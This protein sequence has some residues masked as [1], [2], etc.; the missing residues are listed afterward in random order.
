MRMKLT[1]RDVFE[2]KVFPSEPYEKEGSRKFF[3][4]VKKNEFVQ[5]KLILKDNPYLVYDVD[6]VRGDSLIC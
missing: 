1:L 5:V 3:E 6:N 4:M 2:L